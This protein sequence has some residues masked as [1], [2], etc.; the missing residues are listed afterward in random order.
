[1]MP[2]LL[3]GVR[4]L[5]FGRYIAGPFCSALLADLGA[6]VIRVEKVGGGEDRYLM[7]VTE[8]ND[9][10]F[11]LQVNRGKRG[12]T[13]DVSRREGQMV[14]Q[15]L[16]PTADVV[17]A[18]LPDASLRRLGL[19]YESLAVLRPDIILTS[20]SAF[21][22]GGSFSNK[23]G[24]DAVG[25]AMSGIMYLSGRPGEPTKA[26]CPYVD[27]ST[28]LVATVG[29][30][31]ALLAR[32]QTGQGQEVRASLLAT[33][34]TVANGAIIEQAMTQPDRVASLNRSQTQAPSD[35]YRT[36]DGWVF[37]QCIGQPLFQRWA[38]LM[39]D[40]LW[41]EDPRFASDKTR[42]DHGDLISERMAAWCSTRTSSQVLSELEQVKIPAGPVLSP[43]QVL[44]DAHVKATG[45]LR[46]ITVPGSTAE[47][48]VAD[49]PFS[50]SGTV[51]EIRH[52][53]PKLGEHTDAILKELG[54]STPA[55]VALRERGVI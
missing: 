30:M 11:Y 27:F 6:E 52:R 5:D 22:S 37:V 9:G 21:G 45:F 43:Q 46:G 14:L 41:L 51:A 15:R 36:R 40:S 3:Q 16:V 39:G 29:T 28:A 25:Q 4:V 20:V 7:P 55:M 8:L 48:P 2:D 24:F 47:V 49:T 17:V 31:A 23:L 10:G 42:G 19:D 35:A 26:Y 32:F 44:E 50:L 54:Y 13:L 34:L 1:M 38:E 18:N 33:A 12:M 53:A